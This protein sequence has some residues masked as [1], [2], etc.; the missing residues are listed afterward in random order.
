MTHPSGL[1]APY[2]QR[3][4]TGE[5]VQGPPRATAERVVLRWRTW[6]PGTVVRDSK[7]PDGPVHCYTPHEWACFLDGA[8]A[9][10][11]DRPRP[12]SG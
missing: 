5:L 4:R 7:N 12:R 9:Q 10:E 8:R 3:T 1:L 11:F 2:S 6:S